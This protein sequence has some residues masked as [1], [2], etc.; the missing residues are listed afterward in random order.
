[1][2]KLSLYKETKSNDYRFFDR[3]I[4]EQLEIGGT[5]A[6][7]HKYLGPT[8]QGPSADATQ[9]QYDSMDP[10]NIQDLLFL[11]NRDR[12]YDPDIVRL[13]IH[14]SVQNLDFDLSQFGLFLNNDILFMVG[15]LNSMIETLGRKL[16]V[17]DVIELPH[18]I[19][20]NPLD[21]GIPVSLKRYYQVTD[22]NFASEGFSPTWYPHLWRIK[23]EHLVNSQ[24][25]SQ[26]LNEPNNKDNYLG[27]WNSTTAYPAGYVVSFGDV[28]YK[29]IIDTPAGSIPPDPTYWAVDG[30]GALKDAI[31]AYNKNI[32]INDATLTE[33]H[34]QVQKS[35]YDNTMLYVVPTY[36]P[37]SDQYGE[38]GPPQTLSVPSGPPTSATVTLMRSPKYKNPSAA[39][40]IPKENKEM[41]M[42]FL[43]MSLES[44]ELPPVKS[45]T[46][47]GPMSGTMMLV[48]RSMG[49]ISG[50]YGTADNTYITSD[51]DP[52]AVGFDSAILPELDYRV[53]CD[54]R[55][56]YIRRLTPLNFGYADGYMTG[57]GNAPNGLP[58]GAGIS[59][60]PSPNEGDY[61]LRIDYAPQILYR[62]D[63]RLWVRISKNVRT[64]T[65]MKYENKSLQ[66][67]FI[68]NREETRLTDGTMIP[69]KQALS[70]ILKLAPDPLPPI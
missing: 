13:K 46:G 12:T 68:N 37:R 67:G 60:P 3:T 1:M 65:G 44:I 22:G 26:V 29:T 32:A 58:T 24:E 59:F 15:H 20:F 54:P 63:G 42:A 55:F 27:L 57:D 28:N 51:V 48:A 14:Y 64:E 45:D 56:Q 25:F 69:Q 9:P 6:Y 16:M 49:P 18:L 43:Q 35:G 7:I 11:E 17:G 52:G 47:S 41:L 5:F 62:W 19:D 4:K 36:G 50:P 23:C 34:N 40:R 8:D 70:S 10:T 39:L 33:A 38:P 31:T 66:S 30:G 2:P 21:T 61:F 53:D